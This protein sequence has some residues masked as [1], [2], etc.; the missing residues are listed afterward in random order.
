MK[1]VKHDPLVSYKLE[2][3][4]K[5][6]D[7]ITFRVEDRKLILPDMPEGITAVYGGTDYVQVIDGDGRIRKPLVDTQV[8]VE[9]KLYTA[10]DPDV[11]FLH[12][13]VYTIPGAFEASKSVNP[14][15]QV[16]PE[17]QQWFGHTGQFAFDKHSRIVVSPASAQI[18]AEA[19]R[20]MAKDCL[21]TAGRELEVVYSA[22]PVPGDLFF[23]A[24]P[25][26]LEEE[27]YELKIGDVLTVHA[28]H[29]AGAYWATRT[30]LQLLMQKD[31]AIPRGLVRDYP[32]FQVRGFALDAGRGPIPMDF[33]RSWVKEMAWYKLNDFNIHLSDE[34]FDLKYSGFR[35]ESGVPNLTSRD[36]F[37]TKAEFR[38]FIEESGEIGV[39]IV[40][41]LDTPG[42][43]LAYVNARPD[44]GRPN[45]SGAPHYLDVTNPGSLEFVKDIFS[46]YMDGDDPVFP[47]GTVINIGT[48]EYK[49]GS[50]EE[51]EAFRFYQDQLLRY[52]R[53]EKGYPPRLWGSQ[54]ENSGQTPVTAENVEMYMWYV[55]YA[56]AQEMYDKGYK[57]IN[58]NDEDVYLVPGADYYND[59]LDKQRILHTYDPSNIYG[60]LKLPAGDPQ[61]LG[62][63]YALWQDMTGDK[64]MGFT[65]RDYY[66]RM[67]HILPVFSERLWS[68]VLDYDVED[69]DRLAE[70]FRKK[71]GE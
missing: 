34:T 38:S 62:G 9:Y 45:E 46:E 27:T 11:P 60:K 52:I 12:E 66:D 48:D 39:R 70:G 35:L 41:E 40:P 8:A 50:Q 47:K 19:A 15:P 42:H 21:E 16:L 25:A 22:Q 55:G 67:R 18:C 61:V 14:K 29:Q 2:E 36:L 65:C 28:S 5:R 17:L 63:A 37:Y 24:S 56:D 59:Y 10:D 43:A 51:K 64:D 32:K 53:D 4:G 6:L 26:E 3:A 71:T 30:I 49:G 69:I 23:E 1:Q 58:I 31:G 33:L 54:T 13:S 44:L 7:S 57:L 68:S 20:E